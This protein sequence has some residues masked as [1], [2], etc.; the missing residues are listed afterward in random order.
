MS[1]TWAAYLLLNQ[2]YRLSP[3]LLC[4]WRGLAPVVVFTPLLLL[5]G[6]PKDPTYYVLVAL[7]GLLIGFFDRHL[8]AVAAQYGSGALS[9]LLSLATPLAFILWGIVSPSHFADLADKPYIGLLPIA[10]IGMVVSI[11]LMRQNHVSRAALIATLPLV[12]ASAVIDVLLKMIFTLEKGLPA[13]MGYGAVSGVAVIAV[14]LFWR[15]PHDPRPLKDGL[16]LRK[17]IVVGLAAGLIVV[18]AQLVKPPAIEGAPNPAFVTAMGL[19]SPVWVMVWNRISGIDDRSHVWAG[20]ACVFSALL[21]LIA[22][23]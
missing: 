10:M 16:F 3:R 12:G 7:V 21:L 2:H 14:N 13:Y 4:L 1:F 11:M 23:A 19:L 17:T 8:F 15:D 18:V 20:V 22:T 5:H 6:A 9:R